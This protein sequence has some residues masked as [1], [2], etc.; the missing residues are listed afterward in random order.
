MANIQTCFAVN[1]VHQTAQYLQ[2]Q[3]PNCKF[4]VKGASIMVTQSAGTGVQLKAVG[5]HR[6]EMST[7]IPGAG[8]R[9][10]IGSLTALGMVA[11]IIPG[12]L[13]LAI[14]SACANSA[15]ATL[16][17]HLTNALQSPAVGAPQGYGQHH[18]YPTHGYPASNG[19]AGHAAAHRGYGQW[20]TTAAPQGNSPVG[21]M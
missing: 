19:A 16:R 7:W 5:V 6:I 1:H 11:G 8:W 12:I 14:A 17:K 9:L 4:E 3:L 13:V 10:L 20:A 18:G 15:N 21:H 2:T